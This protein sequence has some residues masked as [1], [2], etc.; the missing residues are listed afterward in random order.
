MI[1]TIFITNPSSVYDVFNDIRHLDTGF[2]FLKDQLN[3]NNVNEE[4]KGYFSELVQLS[5]ALEKNET[6]TANIQEELLILKSSFS[7]KE[8]DF[9]DKS[10]IDNKSL[11]ISTLYTNTLSKIEPR[12]VI[13]GDNQY[14]KDPLVASKI[15]T[16]LF[17]GLT[18]FGFIAGFK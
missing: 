11:K 18:A 15:R 1:Y 4:A 13:I 2:K 14:L 7:N 9:G 8:I 12:I 10:E 17:A 3:G 5:K 16:S 6:I